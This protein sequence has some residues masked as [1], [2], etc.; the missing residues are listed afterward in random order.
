MEAYIQR[1]QKVLQQVHELAAISEDSGALTRTY[2]SGAW[3]QARHSLRQWM[4]AAGLQTRIDAIGNVR[5]RLPAGP[6]TLVIASHFD[7]VAQAGKFDGTLG[8]LMGLDLLRQLG[9]GSN[10]CPSAWS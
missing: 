9:P 5:G 4:E 10:R 8:V 3:L 6:Q 7:T 2:G 1:A